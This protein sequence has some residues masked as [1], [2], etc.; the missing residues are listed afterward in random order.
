MN[1]DTYKA[2][3]FR[4]SQRLIKRRKAIRNRVLTLCIPLA[5]V[6]IGL[7]IAP[8]LME[9]K[10]EAFEQETVADTDGCTSGS[11][12]CSY[13]K[14]EL[15][16]DGEPMT[17]THKLTVDKLFSIA[18]DSTVA[19]R[20]PAADAPTVPESATEAIVDDPPDTGK[21]E[22]SNCFTICFTTADGASQTYYLTPDQYE[23]IL[24]VLK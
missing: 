15:Y 5:L 10:D 23:Q 16:M 14:A 11:I 20:Y 22:T 12:F 7:L 9:K 1:L 8:P 21:L 24:E 17:I 18:A 2:E 13:V 4:R 19:G 3:I 6:V